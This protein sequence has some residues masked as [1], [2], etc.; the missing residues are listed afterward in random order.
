MAISRL[1][2]GANASNTVT[3]NSVYG[4]DDCI[5][6]WVTNNATA[7]VPTLPAGWTSVTS[8]TANNQAAI[9]AYKFAASTSES[10]GTWTN[11]TAI[12]YA[13]YRGVDK[14]T[15]FT[16]AAGQTGT[17]STTISYSGI[18]SFSN[19]GADWVLTMS[20]ISNQTGKAYSHPGT[21]QFYHID[22]GASTYEATMYDSGGAVASYSFNS[23]TLSA[24]LNSMTKTV[25][26]VA[27]KSSIVGGPNLQQTVNAT[28]AG[29]TV[30]AT[31]PN[32]SNTGSLL[33]AA[34]E[35]GTATAPGTSVSDSKSN[36]W[37]KLFS[38]GNGASWTEF[39]YAYDITGGS[40]HTVT[41][42]N[43]NSLGVNFIV[44]EY[45]GILFTGSPIDVS[46]TA[47]GTVAAMDTGSVTTTNANDLVIGVFG[48]DWQAPL[49]YTPGSSYGNFVTAT[50]G[51]AGD[52]SLIDLQT[53]STGS[54]DATLTA[55]QAPS[56]VAA[57]VTFKAAVPEIV[58]V[59]KYTGTSAQT[60]MTF[61]LNQAPVVGNLLIFIAL[62]YTGD[63]PVLTPS[64]WTLKQ[65]YEPN[66]AGV[67]VFYRT[68]Q[69]G[70]GTSW[71]LTPLSVA[72]QNSGFM[73]EI[74]G[75]DSTTPFNQLANSTATGTPT[76]LASGS[77]T[78]SV[79]STLAISAFVNDGSSGTDTATFSAGWQKAGYANST[80]QP[81]WLAS[82]KILT[83]DTSTAVSNTISSMN[84]GG[85]N[86]SSV[87]FLIA[88]PSGSTTTTKTQTGVA[89]ITATTTKTQTGKSRITATT[90]K[91]QTGKSRITATATKTQAGQSRITATT[92]KTQ[93]GKANIKNNTSQTQQGK[94]R[95]TAT[96]TQ[97]QSGKSRITITTLK[98][99]QGLARITAQTLQTILG[100]ARITATT[101]KT[102]TGKANIKNTTTQTQ[103]GKSRIQI[104]STQTQAGKSRIT[105]TTTNTTQGI[106]RITATTLRTVQGLARVTATTT[107]TILGKANIAGGTPR[108]QQGLARITV[109]TLRTI[110]GKAAILRTTSQTQ[111]GKARITITSTQTQQGKAR[112]TATATK[113]QL[114]VSRITVITLKTQSGKARITAS[115]TRTQLGQSR[116]TVTTTR[117]QT[118]Q[119]R[120][121][122]VVPKTQ[123]G[124][125]RITAST[126]KTQP[127]RARITNTSTKTQLGRSRI[128][129][130]TV[131]TQQ[132][133]GRIIIAGVQQTQTGVARI[134]A[135]TLRTILGHSRITVTT[136]AT[137]LGVSRVT[138]TG[139]Q[140]QTGK[141]SVAHAHDQ[142]ITGR[143][144][145]LGPHPAKATITFPSKN[146]DILFP[147]KQL[148]IVF[149]NN[150]LEVTFESDVK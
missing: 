144:R 147:N 3:F 7:T 109:T 94:A 33:I 24:S 107:K 43:P 21:N 16:N 114:G 11:A 127:G 38:T 126:T 57:I 56:W 10:S 13:I 22:I 98:T 117:T 136:V 31:L 115:A 50:T 18:V 61:T 108:T 64:G 120:I 87:I 140:T 135:S 8:V 102:Q 128:Q 125:A 5:V 63:D 150:K 111:T 23:K 75:M 90:T 103:A 78:P 6:A 66:Q 86:A 42:S 30:V 85:A 9:L 146:T 51:A 49:T 14:T 55:S 36:T 123:Q 26:L 29:A 58:Q 118:G 20:M 84:G 100:K 45:T 67:A 4:V 96:S 92:T 60:N 137:Q 134:T 104:T 93:L 129:I 25:E 68:V 65:N 71:N 105:V 1:T 110:L 52:I 39:Y 116:I 139:V 80:F 95:V 132:G 35:V 27:S 142:I 2:S 17:G 143:A 82:K 19:P 91:T 130:V 101:T 88:P 106:S 41:V 32:S 121:T 148:S 37:T 47:T 46:A 141:G 62:F 48:D 54:Q 133:V 145:I 113:T 69:S 89:R 40:S 99:I 15:P 28:G 97:T 149:P 74:S 72:D 77:V 59:A 12:N 73:L 124:I 119:S 122:Q 131:Q 112:V 79:V 81:A 138:A 76:S 83:L 70:D 34:V 44:R 53:T